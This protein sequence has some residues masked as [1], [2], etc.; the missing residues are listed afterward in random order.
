VG[1]SASRAA[2]HQL[3]ASLAALALTVHVLAVMP[4]HAQRRLDAADIHACAH[5]VQLT[6][7]LRSRMVSTAEARKRLTLIYDIA[8]TS[9]SPTLQHMAFMHSGQIASAD[10]TLLRVMAEQF[11]AACR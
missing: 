1:D 8:R 7:D 2:G 5:A 4:A 11:S 6:N 10:D 9:S 3:R